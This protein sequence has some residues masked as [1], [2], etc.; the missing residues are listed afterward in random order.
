MVVAALARL[1]ARRVGKI[2]NA[3]LRGLQHVRAALRSRALL[4][5]HELSSLVVHTGLRE[6]VRTWNGK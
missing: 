4:E 6:D 1:R 3:P 2:T 5:Q